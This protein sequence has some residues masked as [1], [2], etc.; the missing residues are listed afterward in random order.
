MDSA[1]D[2][3]WNYAHVTADTAVCTHPCVLHS[4]VLNGLTTVGDATIYDNTVTGGTVIGVLHLAVATSVAVQPIT[5]LYD[6]ECKT[7]LYIEFD[8][9]LVADLTINYK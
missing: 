2:F 6:C 8:G 9:T 4:I 7:G 3:P 5:L 1:K